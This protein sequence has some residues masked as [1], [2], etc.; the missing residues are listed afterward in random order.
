MSMIAKNKGRNKGRESYEAALPLLLGKK[1]GGNL[2]T[3]RAVLSVKEIQNSI[4][5][6]MCILRI[7]IK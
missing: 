3:L 7:V 6:C 1:L 5:I 4:Y 2:K